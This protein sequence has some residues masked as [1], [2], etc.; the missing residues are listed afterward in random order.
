AG[1]VDPLALACG[2]IHRVEL[3]VHLAEIDGSAD[4]D[5]GGI[6]AVRRVVSPLDL[7]RRRKAA[8]DYRVTLRIAQEHRPVG[9]Y[10]QGCQRSQG[11][12]GEQAAGGQFADESHHSTLW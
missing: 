11:C 1:L 9:S 10:G 7:K 8:S 2:Q 4:N 6:D 3:A 12:N 5:G